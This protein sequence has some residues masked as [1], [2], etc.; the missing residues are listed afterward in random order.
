MDIEEQMVNRMV[1]G[2]SQYLHSEPARM[3]VATQLK[4]GAGDLPDVIATITYEIIQQVAHQVEQTDPEMLDL[5]VLFVVVTEIIDMLIE[6][7]EAVGTPIKDEQILR[8]E[9]LFKVVQAHMAV[10]GDDPAAK[11]EMQALMQQLMQ[12]GTWQEGINSI[13]GM[14]QERGGNVDE[15]RAMGQSMANPQKPVAAGVQQ[16]LMSA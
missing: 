5:G 15:V 13:E 4:E 7:A 9:S 6:M 14:I 16:G 10:V 3:T 11:Q 8:E 2:V 12:D 1:E